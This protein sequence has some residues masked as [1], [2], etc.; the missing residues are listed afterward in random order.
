[1]QFRKGKLKFLPKINA[2]AYKSSIYQIHSQSQTYEYPK[3]SNLK[4]HFNQLNSQSKWVLNVFSVKPK[5][6]KRMKMVSFN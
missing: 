1:M 4:Q 6:I 5:L 2:N 3:L